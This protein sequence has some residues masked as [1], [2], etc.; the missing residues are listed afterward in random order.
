MKT[1]V[2]VADH[3]LL[4]LKQISR[5]RGVPLREMIREGLEYALKEWSARPTARVKPVTFKGKG[6]APAFRNAPWS[7]IRNAA[8]VG[9]G[10]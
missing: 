10:S 2:D 6:L 7:A 5:E 4:R 9:R 1:T 3:L 8:Y